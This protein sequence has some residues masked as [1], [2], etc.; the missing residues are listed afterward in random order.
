MEQYLQFKVG[1]GYYSN[2]SE[3]VRDAI[4]RMRDEDGYLR[5]TPRNGQDCV[6]RGLYRFD[7][8]TV[9]RKSRYAWFSDIHARGMRCKQLMLRDIT[10]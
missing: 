4:R 8:S 5:P 9:S 2:A 6:M 3:V 10:Y 1:T 7:I